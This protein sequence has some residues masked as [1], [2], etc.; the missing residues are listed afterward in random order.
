M[1]IHDAHQ[2]SA[3]P[4]HFRKNIFTPIVTFFKRR[5]MWTKKY[6]HSY[7]MQS[8]L[9][10]EWNKNCSGMELEC[11]CRGRR[12]RRLKQTM[13]KTCTGRMGWM[14]HRKWKEV[15]RQPSMLPGPAV[16]VS[17]LVSFHFLWA[18]HPIRPVQFN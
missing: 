18:I 7:N 9:K 11:C 13:Q 15:K 6:L 3:S 14:S 4:S 1:A 2:A 16:P 8:L 5:F 10:H 17:C 12:R